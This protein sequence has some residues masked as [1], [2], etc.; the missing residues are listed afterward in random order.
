M[1]VSKSVK[2]SLLI[3]AFA[4]VSCT[5]RSSTTDSDSEA[6]SKSSKVVKQE[7]LLGSDCTSKALPESFKI[8]VEVEKQKDET[9]KPLNINVVTSKSKTAFKWLEDSQGISMTD[10][11]C[12]DGSSTFSSFFGSDWKTAPNGKMKF[13]GFHK[14]QLA[15]NCQDTDHSWA[16]LLNGET[17]SCKLAEG[18]LKKMLP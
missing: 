12:P 2:A 10:I 14:S 17:I 11:I 18:N 7:F 16:F 13:E 9:I 4:A 5:S 6:L 15:K 3:S 8:T 1:S